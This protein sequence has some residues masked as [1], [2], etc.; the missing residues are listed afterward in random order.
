MTKIIFYLTFCLSFQSCAVNKETDESLSG[1][2]CLIDKTQLNYPTIN[3]GR[4]SIAIFSSKMDTVYY[5]KYY[6][7]N[8]YLCLVQPNGNI[9]KE[10]ILYFNEDSLTFKSLL[11]NSKLQEYIRCK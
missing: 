6:K 9:I 2:W 1:R 3:F 4:D 11:E 8:N 7:K 10:R 5:F